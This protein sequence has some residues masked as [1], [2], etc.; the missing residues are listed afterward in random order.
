MLQVPDKQKLYAAERFV[1][2]LIA[3]QD[4]ADG[5]QQVGTHHADLVDHQQVH[6]ANDIDLVLA[7]LVLEIR[8]ASLVFR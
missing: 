4:I 7:E 2:V 5:V 8:F 3:A 6:A 1:A